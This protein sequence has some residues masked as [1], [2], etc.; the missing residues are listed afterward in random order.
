MPSGEATLPRLLLLGG[1]FTVIGIAWM[2]IYG[3]GVTRLRALVTSPRVRRWMERTT[4]TVLI[5]LG[6]RLAL[7][8]A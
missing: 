6:A 4:G 8:R 7:D 3:L 2:N 1:I 5:A